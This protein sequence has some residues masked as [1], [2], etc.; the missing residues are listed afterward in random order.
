MRTR[1]AAKGKGVID[2]R[3]PDTVLTAVAAD[4]RRRHYSAS[5]VCQDQQAGARFVA[6]EQ[7]VEDD[8]AMSVGDATVQFGRLH[9]PSR[10]SAQICSHI[11]FEEVRILRNDVGGQSV[12]GSKTDIEIRIGV[13]APIPRIPK[14][15]IHGQIRHA[16]IKLWIGRMPDKTGLGMPVAFIEAVILVG[17]M[18]AV[19]KQLRMLCPDGPVI[20]VFSQRGRVQ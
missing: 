10:G 3:R 16:V 17:S 11:F 6:F 14:G 9:Q 20:D 1:G 4:L 13:A 7:E 18:D 5:L 15:R 2:L 8:N 19:I 12:V